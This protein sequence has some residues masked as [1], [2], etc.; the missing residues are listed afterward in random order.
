M[1][2]PAGP[3]SGPAAAPLS[4]P[5]TASAHGLP[6][7]ECSITHVPVPLRLAGSIQVLRPRGQARA[8]ARPTAW[9]SSTSPRGPAGRALHPDCPAGRGDGTRRMVQLLLVSFPL[10]E[11][12][13]WGH[14]DVTPSSSQLTLGHFAEAGP[15]SWGPGLGAFGK[16]A[17][18]V[19]RSWGLEWSP[20]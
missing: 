3:R 11:R 18:L 7:H 13:G 20:H 1:L 8:G 14:G 16:T 5:P 19:L 15:N 10:A 6:G 2:T 17:L 9:P 4:S 12:L